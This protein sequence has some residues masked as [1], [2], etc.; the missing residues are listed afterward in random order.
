LGTRHLKEVERLRAQ[1]AH[2]HNHRN[3]KS[4]HT[5]TSEIYF[6]RRR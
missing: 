4:L 5:N 3:K 2:E 1:R 6:C